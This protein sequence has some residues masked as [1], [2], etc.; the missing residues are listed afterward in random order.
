MRRQ[1]VVKLTLAAGMVGL[2]ILPALVYTQVTGRV[3]NPRLRQTYT[4]CR[5]LSQP[6]QLT[7]RSL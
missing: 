2:L 6:Q 5:R 1:R 7:I 4:T 3:L